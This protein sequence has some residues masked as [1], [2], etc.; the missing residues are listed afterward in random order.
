MSNLIWFVEVHLKCEDKEFEKGKKYLAQII[1]QDLST[2]SQDQIDEA[3]EY[4]LPSGL[5]SFKARPKFK[6]I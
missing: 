1:G 6:V 4:L 3:I 5:F 2:L